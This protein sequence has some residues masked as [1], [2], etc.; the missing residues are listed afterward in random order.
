MGVKKLQQPVSIT[1]VLETDQ[2]E[3]LRFM[4]YKEH[5]S[6]ADLFRTAVEEFIARKS[7]EYPIPGRAMSQAPP[8]AGKRRLS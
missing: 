4:A 2:Y 3:A 8:K 1:T 5:R 6:L 7:R